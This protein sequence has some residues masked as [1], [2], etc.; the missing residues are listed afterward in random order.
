MKSHNTTPG[1]SG[2]TKSPS[3]GKKEKQP[4]R[5]AGDSDNPEE[6]RQLGSKRTKPIL[7]PNQTKRSRTDHDRCGSNDR[8][9]SDSNQRDEKRSGTSTSGVRH[10]RHKGRYR[11]HTIRTGQEVPSVPRV[12]R[13]QPA[14]RDQCPI[15]KT[16]LTLPSYLY[17]NLQLPQLST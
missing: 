3:D 13:A 16:I 8:R 6:E 10:I 11:N 17:P 1:K 5:K 14:P 4:K 12:I 9:T 2:S 15:P 7:I